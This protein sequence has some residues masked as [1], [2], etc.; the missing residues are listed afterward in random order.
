[1]A[2][3]NTGKMVFYLRSILYF[4]DLDTPHQAASIIDDMRGQW[5]MHCHGECSKANHPHTTYGLWT[6]GHQVRYP[7]GVV[8]VEQ[9]LMILETIGTSINKAD[10]FTIHKV[11]DKTLFYRH[12]DHIMGRIPPQYSIVPMLR[13]HIGD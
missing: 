6:Y 9:D 13:L 11:L 12:V 4:F 1:M 5:R 8:E 10:H 2:G 7:F 3:Y